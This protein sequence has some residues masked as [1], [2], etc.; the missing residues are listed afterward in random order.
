MFLL[1]MMISDIPN[2][3][4]QFIYID[5]LYIDNSVVLKLKLFL[6]KLDSNGSIWTFRDVAEDQD[7]PSER[8]HIFRQ[9][10]DRAGP[11]S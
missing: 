1:N 8:W 3:Y 5:I 4:I 10:M 7:D 6:D 2:I 11:D 9:Q